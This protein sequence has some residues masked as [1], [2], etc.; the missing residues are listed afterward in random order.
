VQAA[1]HARQ[2]PGHDVYTWLAS[3]PPGSVAAAPPVAL[4]LELEL[5]L[6]LT[7]AAAAVRASGP[8]TSCHSDSQGAASMDQ[9][10]GWT[11]G[12]VPPQACTAAAAV[13]DTT[14]EPQTQEDVELWEALLGG[15]PDPLNIRDTT[16][17][18]IDEPLSWGLFDIQDDLMNVLMEH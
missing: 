6:V 12:G 17:A 18:G 3:G 5:E 11:A 10:G 1:A 4:D 8:R 14:G 2:A 9:V 15:V 13:Q 16:P 7:S